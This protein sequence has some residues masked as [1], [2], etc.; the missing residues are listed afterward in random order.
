VEVGDAVYSQQVAKP[1]EILP[2]AIPQSQI[3]PN[4]EKLKNN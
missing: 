3:E 4:Q 1:A 2:P